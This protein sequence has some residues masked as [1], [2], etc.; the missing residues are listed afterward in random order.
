M[1]S[2]RVNRISL[3]RENISLLRVKQNVPHFYKKLRIQTVSTWSKT[4]K[5]VIIQTA[6]NAN[7]SR[8]HV[9]KRL[10]MAASVLRQIYFP[11]F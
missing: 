8:R 2:D 3:P 9:I 7:D 6:A 1:C 10:L 11:Q 5:L 4:Q